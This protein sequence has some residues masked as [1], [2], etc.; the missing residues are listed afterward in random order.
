[1][2][3][4]ICMF[5]FQSQA[6]VAST[7]VQSGTTTLKAT[8]INWSTASDLEV[9]L[10]AIEQT[11]PLPATDTP[12]PEIFNT[13]K[14]YTVQHLEDWPPLPGNIWGLPFW[15]LGGG[16]IL[17][18]DRAVDYSALAAAAQ[19]TKMRLMSTHEPMCSTGG[20]PSDLHTPFR[21]SPASSAA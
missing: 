7:S 10:A 15:D 2:A 17:L 18:D 13:V 19:V 6:Q 3:L 8:N 9:M 14:F 5:V 16:V 20:T 21:P 11:T 1:M 4:A 12:D